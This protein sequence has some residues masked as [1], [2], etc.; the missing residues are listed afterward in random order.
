MTEQFK[1]L[2]NQSRDGIIDLNEAAKNLQVQ[3]RRIYD[4]TNVLE[5]VELIRKFSKNRIQWSNE[6]PKYISAHDVDSDMQNRTELEKLS[7]E[8]KLIDDEIRK[9]EALVHNLIEGEYSKYAYITHE[10]IRKLPECINHTI[11]AIK[12]PKGTN[13]EVPD[14]DYTGDNTK[15]YQIYLQNNDQKPIDVYLLSQQD[16]QNDMPYGIT[17]SFTQSVDDYSYMEEMYSI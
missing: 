4:I 1:R 14:P 3:K 12:A 6:A 17:E 7:H 11:I 13:L 2:I 9:Y 10:D 16:P 5:G 15:V 8:E